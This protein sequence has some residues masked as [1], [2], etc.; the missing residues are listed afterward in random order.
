MNELTKLK[1]LHIQRIKDLSKWDAP[2]SLE[3]LDIIN[4]SD[5]SKLPQNIN[6]LSNLK[7]L[8]VHK[9][10]APYI[11]SILPNQDITVYIQQEKNPIRQ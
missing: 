2:T 7:V 5:I 8:S 9:K 6:N 10:L 4:I 1:E 3:E 11:N